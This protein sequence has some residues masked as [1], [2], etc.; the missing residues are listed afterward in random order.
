MSDIGRLLVFAGVALVVVG[1]VV[2]L[3]DRFPGLP[4]GKL[5]GDFS[6]ERGDVKIHVPLATM[7]I[8]SIIL[9]LLVNVIWRLL[10]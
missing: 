9:T 3:L 1:A 2:L 8:V 5:P 10:R 4:V 7:V 6:W